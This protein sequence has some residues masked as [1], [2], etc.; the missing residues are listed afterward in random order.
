MDIQLYKKALKERGWIY[1]DLANATGISLGNIKRIMAGIVKNPR[2][3]TVE[4][5][6]KALAINVYPTA[7]ERA[8]GAMSTR[9]ETITPLED[10][11]L[12]AF[13]KVGEKLGEKG[14]QSLITLAENMADLR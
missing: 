4:A 5:I 11:M 13:R 12:Y 7:E 14:Q 2:Y 6:E 8:S 10:D 1:D 3:S 9:R